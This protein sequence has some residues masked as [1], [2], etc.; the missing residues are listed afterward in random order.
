MV[1]GVGGRDG[2]L[3]NA[4]DLHLAGGRV[5]GGRALHFPGHGAAAGAAAGSQ[6]ER[7]AVDGGIGFVLN[8]Q[9]RLSCLADGEVRSFRVG[10]GQIVVA[11]R[12]VLNRN[13]VGALVGRCS[14][15]ARPVVLRIGHYCLDFPLLELDRDRGHLRIAVVLKAVGGQLDDDVGQRLALNGHIHGL[16]RKMVVILISHNLIID[17]VLPRLDPCGDGGAI[18]GRRAVQGVLDLAAAGLARNEQLMGLT[19]VDNDSRG[20]IS[21]EHDIRLFNYKCR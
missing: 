10:F 2:D 16:Y 1:S 19:V 6:R 20:R 17:G 14:V 11:A 15:A 13:G 12:E 5:H 9:L 18:G 4:C 7:I 3:A 21:I 8:H